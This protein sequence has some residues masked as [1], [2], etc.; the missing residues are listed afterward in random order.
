MGNVALLLGRGDA[1][2]IRCQDVTASHLVAHSIGQ[3]VE[4]KQAGAHPGLDLYL[5]R[6]PIVLGPHAVGAKDMLPGPLAEVSA[7]AENA[8][9]R[10]R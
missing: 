5:L 4:R 3:P 8:G 6:P 2:R 9:C 10:L 7:C 1:A